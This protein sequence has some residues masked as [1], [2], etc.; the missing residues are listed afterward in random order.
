MLIQHEI[1]IVL[2]RQLC[3]RERAAAPTPTARSPHA[4]TALGTHAHHIKKITVK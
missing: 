3:T 4:K 2:L 1:I